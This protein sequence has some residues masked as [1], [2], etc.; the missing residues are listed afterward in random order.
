ML[1]VLFK[2]WFKRTGNF[3]DE[4]LKLDEFMLELAEVSPLP[5]R[6]IAYCARFPSC[7]FRGALY[8]YPPAGELIFWTGYLPPKC[9]LRWPMCPECDY[10]SLTV[11]ELLGPHR[12]TM[13]EYFEGK[14]DNR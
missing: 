9:R 2:H 3:V 11:A 7:D 13:K 10:P 5:P 12:W 8:V 14:V 1:P 4:K 6:L